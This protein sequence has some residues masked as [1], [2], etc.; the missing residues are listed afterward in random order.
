MDF[1]QFPSYDINMNNGA[2]IWFRYNLKKQVNGFLPTHLKET[3][4]DSLE[5][6]L[7]GIIKKYT[8]PQ[9]L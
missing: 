6:K 2:V 5:Y 7:D 9:S 1:K 3:I 8:H 4:K